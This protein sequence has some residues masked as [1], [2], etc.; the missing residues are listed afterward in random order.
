LIEP[1]HL[2]LSVARQCELLKLSR[3]GFYYGPQGEG[4]ENLHLM[5][6]L[7]EQYTRTPF[8]KVDANVKTAKTPVEGG[9]H[10]FF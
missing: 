6:L 5:R 4:A 7:D 2:H 10:S 3:A 9:C 1:A 8:Y